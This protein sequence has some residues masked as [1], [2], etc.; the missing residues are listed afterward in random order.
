MK[1]LYVGNIPYAATDDNLFNWFSECGK[2]ASANVI[3]DRATG[4][5]KG[6]AFV[7][8]SSESEAQNA[9]NTLN[10]AEVDGRSI[11]VSLARERRPARFARGGGD[12]Y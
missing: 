4:R 6:F 9:I 1:R 11:R 12:R 7:E 3:T 2:V 10:G 5:S 8:M